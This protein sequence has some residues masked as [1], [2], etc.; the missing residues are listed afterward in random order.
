MSENKL[1]GAAGIGSAIL[2]FFGAE[3]E[4]FRLA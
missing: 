2:H 4:L 3:H 1:Y